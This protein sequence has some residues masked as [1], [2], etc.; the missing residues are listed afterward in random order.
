MYQNTYLETVI[1]S[2]NTTVQMEIGDTS[3][4]TAFSITDNKE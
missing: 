4:E 3:Y 2:T 1:K